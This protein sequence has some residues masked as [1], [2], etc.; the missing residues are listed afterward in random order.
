MKA[1]KKPIEALTAAELGE[2][3]PYGGGGEG[4]ATLSVVEVVEPA[5]RKGGVMVGSV[6]ELVA[7][8][9]DEAKVL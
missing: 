5:K 2:A 1:K 7:K 6:A 3:D 8:L 9:R 4:A